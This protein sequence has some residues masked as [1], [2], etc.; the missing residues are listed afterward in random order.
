MLCS[1]TQS[2]CAKSLKNGKTSG[3]ILFENFFTQ[4]CEIQTTCGE[5]LFSIFVCSFEDTQVC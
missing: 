2:L 4:M 3:I 5:T 1:E